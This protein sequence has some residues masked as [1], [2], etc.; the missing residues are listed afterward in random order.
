M[1]S[2]DANVND[3]LRTYT[4]GSMIRTSWSIY[5]REWLT[6][7]LIYVI[8]LLVVHIIDVLAK[9]LWGQDVLLAAAV[10]ALQMLA[11][12]FA[13]FP[14][15][16]AVS[17]VCLGIKPN[18]VRS[19]RR[20]FAQP[21]RA[22]GTYFLAMVIVILGLMA[23]LVP[24][25][26]FSLWYILVGSVVI[27]EGLAGRAA[28]KRS[29][30]LGRGYYL[31]NFGIVF[32]ATLIVLLAVMV[33]SGAVGAAAYF[34]GGSPLVTELSGGLIA[35]LLSPPN[36]V[37]VVLLYYDMRVRKEGYGAAQLADD[38]RF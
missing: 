14:A 8:P 15:T 20:A 26:V 6:L 28:L 25:I 21:A 29:R 37:L 27:L 36:I 5:R 13:A 23:L 2:G 9:R 17:E 7:L 35:L 30:E 10:V 19:Y 34:A 33:L 16:V 4:L 3:L 18:V 24:G 1:F 11:G 32:V 31:R 12:M 38:L 22:M